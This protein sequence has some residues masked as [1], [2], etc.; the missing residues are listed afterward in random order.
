MPLT[1]LN[2]LGAAWVVLE[3]GFTGSTELTQVSQTL[4]AIGSP[5]VTRYVILQNIDV[6]AQ[7]ASVPANHTSYFQDLSFLFYVICTWK[8]SSHRVCRG[9]HRL[10]R[11]R[12]CLCRPFLLRVL[13]P[14]LPTALAFSGIMG[15][16][17]LTRYEL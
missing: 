3:F 17:M 13:C 16:N 2:N 8:S 6:D 4:D 10:I 5:A 11:L 9:K 7:G 1:P 15:P 12:L 14:L